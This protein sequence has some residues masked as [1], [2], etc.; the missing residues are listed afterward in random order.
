[1]INVDIATT[2]SEYTLNNVLE[3]SLKQKLIKGQINTQ[4]HGMNLR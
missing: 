4:L 3:L 2:F 1:M